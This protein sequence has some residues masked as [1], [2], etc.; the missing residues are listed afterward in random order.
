VLAFRNAL[1][2]GALN[3]W[4]QITELLTFFIFFGGIGYFVFKHQDR[5]LKSKETLGK[6]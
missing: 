6:Y 4:M 1:L 3:Q 5:Y 2:F